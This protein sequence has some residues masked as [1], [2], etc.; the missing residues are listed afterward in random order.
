MRKIKENEIPE[1][2]ARIT[3]VELI[4]ADE[5]LGKCYIRL[6]FG[7]GGSATIYSTRDGKRIFSSQRALVYSRD[8]L[9]QAAVRVLLTEGK[10]GKHE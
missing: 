2:L 3:G 10:E 7:K 6:L 5:G 1:H 8:I 4:P 9:E